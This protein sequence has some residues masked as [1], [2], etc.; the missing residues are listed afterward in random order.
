VMKENHSLSIFTK[1]FDQLDFA[2]TYE[3]NFLCIQV[4]Y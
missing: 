2:F 1:N 3:R 4:H